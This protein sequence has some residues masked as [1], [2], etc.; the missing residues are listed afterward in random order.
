MHA[1]ESY[2]P[3]IA[4]ININAFKENLTKL[5]QIAKNSNLLAVI[6]TDGYGHGIVPIGH[7]AVQAGADRL[8]ITTVAEGALLRESGVKNPIQLLSAIT[9]EQA[10]A[11]VAN[12]LTA[13][14]SSSQIAIAISNEAKKQGTTAAVHLKID[15]GLHRFG[16]NPEQAVA[17]CRSCFSLPGLYWEGIYTHFSCAD[18]GDWQTTNQQFHLF[19]TTVSDLDKHGFHFPLHHVAGSTITMKRNDWHLDM[20]R[21]GIALF[22]YHPD[23]RQQNILP[24]KPVLTLK[25]KIL[26]VRELPPHTPVGYGGEYVTKTTEKI[27]VVPIGHGDGYQRILSNKGEML[28]KGNRAGIVGTISLDQTL[29]NVTGISDVNEGDEVVIIGE[30]GDDDIPAY[31]IADWMNS[32]VDEVLASLMERIPR[33]YI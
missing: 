21:P 12:Q 16:V 18:E 13:S 20:V 10:G 9:P 8:G 5:K 3:T 6:K 30:Q 15:T 11:V 4:E 24:L 22:G 2:H 32:I 27:A 1:F 23:R 26:Q 14:I 33:V 7:A 25:S 29:I 31:E 28:V 19:T 17:V